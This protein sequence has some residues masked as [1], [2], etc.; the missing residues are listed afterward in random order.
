MFGGAPFTPPVS[1][2]TLNVYYCSLHLP[3]EDEWSV[4]VFN[5]EFHTLEYAVDQFHPMHT[6]I[7]F[8]TEHLAGVLVKFCGPR[9]QKYTLECS[10][11]T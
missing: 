9:W 3:W 1:Y 5:S 11:R 8:R 2:V 6:P 10:D 4:G 7:E